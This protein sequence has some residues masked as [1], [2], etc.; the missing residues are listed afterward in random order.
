MQMETRAVRAAL[1][2]FHIKLM[3]IQIRFKMDQT[4][5]YYLS[6]FICDI[7]GSRG[8][9]QTTHWVGD[10]SQLELFLFKLL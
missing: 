4:I 3:V 7:Q 10:L 5:S 1:H 9:P 6:V 2:T 8:V